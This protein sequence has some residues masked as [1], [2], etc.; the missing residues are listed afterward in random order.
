MAVELA[1]ALTATLVPAIRAA[2]TNT[3]GALTAVVFAD[4]RLSPRQYGGRARAT[5]GTASP[6]S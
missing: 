5:D 1:V 4:P 6:R 2:G 3:V